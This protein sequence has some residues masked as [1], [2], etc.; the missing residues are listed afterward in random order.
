MPE[1]T[2]L[3]T[4]G[5]TGIG[6]ATA[7]QLAEIGHQI[8]LLTR[9][10]ETGQQ[11]KDRIIAGTNNQKVFQYTC[12]LASFS[13]VRAFSDRLHQDFDRIDVLINNAGIL[14]HERM[15]TE[16]GHEY[17]FQVNHLSHFLLTQLIVDMLRQSPEP[18]IINV[19]SEAHKNGRIHFRDLNLK[20]KYS[21]FKAYSQAKLANVLFTYELCRRL[22]ADG[23][24]AN[25][26]HPGVVGSDFGAGRDGKKTPAIMKLFK[27]IGQSPEKGART[28][29][30][31]ATDEKVKGHSGGYY[32]NRKRNSSSRLSYDPDTATALWEISLKMTGLESS[33]I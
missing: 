33:L 17:Q 2:I 9:K 14:A 15:E 5:N 26:L 10:E 6:Y 27:R 7:F 30:Y 21:P 28:S 12:D 24:T 32:K 8:I 19:S 3:I 31:L 4:G 18:R 20:E 16:D 25:T 29:V 22:S 11:A 1:K 13:Q 23:M